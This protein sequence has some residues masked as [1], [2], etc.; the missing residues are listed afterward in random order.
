GV[1]SSRRSGS[2][3]MARSP[4]QGRG[5][6]LADD[7]DVALAEGTAAQLDL[8]DPVG[9]RALVRVLEASVRHRGPARQP[10]AQ[11]SRPRDRVLT[12]QLVGTVV[13]AELVDRLPRDGAAEL[14]RRAGRPQLRGR[15]L[16]LA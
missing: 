11:V 7:L 16:Q 15:H 8:R 4:G 6:V 10:A 1:E 13:E 2:A 14:A 5:G 3:A 9:S 12:L